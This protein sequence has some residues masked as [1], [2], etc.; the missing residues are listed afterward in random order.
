MFDTAFLTQIAEGVIAKEE[1][2]SHFEET[3][4]DIVHFDF[5]IIQVDAPVF[6]SGRAGEYYKFS[7]EYVLTYFDEAHL[8]GNAQEIRKFRRSIRLDVDGKLSGVGER[9]ELLD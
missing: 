1:E 8:E 4:S 3:G 5:E 9:Q 6:T 7:F 2:R